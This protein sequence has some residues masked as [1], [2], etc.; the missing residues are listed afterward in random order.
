MVQQ[1]Q[2]EIQETR[3]QHQVANQELHALRVTVG[4][5]MNATPNDTHAK[6]NKPNAF[7]GKSKTDKVDAWCAQNLEPQ[8]NT[9]RMSLPNPPD[10]ALAVPYHTGLNYPM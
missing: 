4:T 5:D 6:S 10:R 3:Q 2:Q 8:M 1:L 7:S 9:Y